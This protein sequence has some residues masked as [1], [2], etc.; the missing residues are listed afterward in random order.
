MGTNFLE[1]KENVIRSLDEYI[2]NLSEFKSLI[3]NAD[4]DG[5]RVTM[6]DT[7]YIK[8]ILNGIKE[9]D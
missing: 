9:N 8:S 2:K 3:E 1:N 5:L 4:D 6:K 7:N